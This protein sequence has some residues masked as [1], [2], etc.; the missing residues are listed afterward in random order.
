M[1]K[2]GHLTLKIIALLV[3]ND[4]LDSV[5][6]IFMKKGLLT[7][8]ISSIGSANLIE[9]GFRSLSSPYLWLGLSIYIISF[10]LW[11]VV[12]ARIEL[13]IALPVSSVC[14][15]LTPLF[16]VMFL[17]EKVSAVRWLGIFLIVAGIYFVSESKRKSME[18]S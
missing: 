13:S 3:A 1:M 8:G 4:L 12:L 16:A 17:H 2:P 18:A 10:F 14:Y 5:A 6:Q 9:F 15:V 7:T 11:I